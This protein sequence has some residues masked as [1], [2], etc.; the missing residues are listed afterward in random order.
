MV[1]GP[2]VSY[3]VPAAGLTAAPRYSRHSLTRSTSGSGV[4]RLAQLA[5]SWPTG[6]RRPVSTVPSVAAAKVTAVPAGASPLSPG[7]TVTVAVAGDTADTVV[8]SWTPLPLTDRPGRT[9]AVAGKA[10]TVAPAEA[11]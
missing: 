10:S 1:S 6:P 11:V 8:P 4:S 9:P 2:V 5:V 3:T 7:V